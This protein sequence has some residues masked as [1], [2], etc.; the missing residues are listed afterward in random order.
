VILG[1]ARASKSMDYF[2]RNAQ[3]YETWW[4]HEGS[5]AEIAVRQSQIPQRRLHRHPVRDDLADALDDER[6]ALLHHREPFPDRAAETLSQRIRTMLEHAPYCERD[7]RV[8]EELETHTERGEFEVR[9]KVRDRLTRH[10]LDYHP[11]DVVGWDGYLYPWIF[12]IEDFEPITGRIHQPPP[13]HQTFEGTT[14]SSARSCR[15]CST[16]T[17]MAS[18]RRTTTR[19]STRMRSSITPKATSCRARE[20]TAVTSPCIRTACRT[21]RSPA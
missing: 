11:F 10:I 13:A 2:Y 19:T 6:S 21:V 4:V 18:P 3:A 8:P 15:A 17:P 7:I 9:V 12:N 20:S 1:V 14:S 5:G 16:I